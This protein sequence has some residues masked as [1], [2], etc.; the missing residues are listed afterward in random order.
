[1]SSTL[2]YQAR[3][4]KKNLQT[5]LDENNLKIG[6]LENRIIHPNIR[7][8]EWDELMSRRNNL[9]CRN[10]RIKKILL[11]WEETGHRLGYPD[12]TL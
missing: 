3:D 6:Q 10:Q 11:T 4:E 12:V 9:V 7:P 2:I 5:E 1:M 8:R